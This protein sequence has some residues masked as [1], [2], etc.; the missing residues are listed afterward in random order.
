[1]MSLFRYVRAALKG[2]FFLTKYSFTVINDEKSANR[3]R[4]ANYRNYQFSLIN[5]IFYFQLG[6]FIVVY[7]EKR[8]ISLK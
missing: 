8:E 7:Q 6:E 2:F 4:E 5:F 3:I 1:M